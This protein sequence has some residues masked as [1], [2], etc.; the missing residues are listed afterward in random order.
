AK[1]IGTHFKEIDD[2]LLNTLQ[3][4]KNEKQSDLL[5]AS[6]N[7]RSKLFLNIPFKKAVNFKFNL[8]YLKYAVLPLFILLLIFFSGKAIKFKKSFSRVV[9]Y[10]LA[11][12]KPA[13]FKFKIKDSLE[14][15]EGKNY[16]LQIE[17][18]GDELPEDAKIIYNQKQFDLQKIRTGLF[19]FNFNQV[20]KDIAFF[21][22]ANNY[23]SDNYNLNVLIKPSI[24]DLKM[25]LVYPKYIHKKNNV[26]TNTGNAIVPQGTI[27]NWQV[28]TQNT[29]S[30]HFH[31][32]KNKVASFTKNTVN[33]FSY[34]KRMLS[35]VSYEISSSNR[36][37]KN[38]E[39]LAYQIRIINDE[40]PKIEVKKVNDSL[41]VESLNFEGT[42][43]DDY[44]V[45]KLELV[46]FK[47]KNPKNKFKKAINLSNAN[48]VNFSSIFP[49]NEVLEKGEN[50]T[51][52][53]LVYDNDGVNGSKKTK[54]RMFSFYQQTEDEKL[55]ETNA[56][57]IQLLNSFQKTLQQ[58]DF[59]Q[60]E[61]K[62][63]FQQ[64][65]AKENLNFNDMF[66]TYKLSTLF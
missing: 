52:Y 50:Y 21:I 1:I 45:K 57:Q 32:N 38:Y 6:I 53:F 20:Q 5:L 54:S 34:K 8:K 16:K 65:N 43:S 39:K 47:N 63:L 9:H 15:I 24:I 7:Q 49:N 11:Y 51:V 55:A 2:K 62:F 3:L 35:P 23:K 30:I 29:D 61:T 66:S 4:F 33:L 17:T 28:Y 36:R 58:D 42:V 44:G 48:Y 41:N 25:L 12:V 26:I 18:I 59:Q 64:M 19:E 56:Q 60:K 31:S 27:I 37:L 40:Y 14:V 22:I 13:P 10:N 46:Y